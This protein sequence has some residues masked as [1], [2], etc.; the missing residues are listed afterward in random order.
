MQ[1][2]KCSR[3]FADLRVPGGPRKLP[4]LEFPLLTCSIERLTGSILRALLACLCVNIFTTEHPRPTDVP[5]NAFFY[6]I[7][8]QKKKYL[9]HAWLT[10]MTA[11]LAT[12]LVQPVT[13]SRNTCDVW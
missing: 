1:V 13:F 4:V 11:G 6:V 3:W 2:G 8:R 12:I 7:V 5:G 9:L 10:K